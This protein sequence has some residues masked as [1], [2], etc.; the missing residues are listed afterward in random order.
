MIEADEKPEL[1]F[2]RTTPSRLM[3]RPPLYSSLQHLESCLFLI[4]LGRFPHALVTCASSVESVMKSILN[5][6]P[7]QFINAEKLFAQATTAYPALRTFD[8]DDLESFRYTRNQIVHYGFSH[9]DDEE[10]AALLLK[11]GLPLLSACY[12]EFFNFELLDGLVVEFGEQLT[13]ALKV[14]QK[15]KDIPDL[16]FSYCFLAFAHLIRW[17]MRQ[18]L[19]ADWENDASVRADE[20]GTKFD[21]CERQKKELERVFGAAWF[22]DCPICDDIG[23]FVCELDEDRLNE[24]AVALTRAACASCGLMVRKSCPFL[25]DALCGEQIG[26]KRTEILHDFGIADA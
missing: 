26:Q 16:H 14:Y 23:T 9:R 25:A 13:I 18:S 3:S 1:N 12:L 15:A 17:S 21:A 7:E 19:M 22:F 6:P 2:F 4:A 20:I 11:I 10:T 8:A 24:R 5:I